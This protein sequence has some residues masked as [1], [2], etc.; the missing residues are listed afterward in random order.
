MDFICIDNKVYCILK[1]TR[2]Y[3]RNLLLM[4]CVPFITWQPV[5]N[6]NMLYRLSCN[7][8]TFYSFSYYCIYYCIPVQILKCTFLYIMIIDCLSLN[9]FFYMC[10]FMVSLKFQKSLGFIVFVVYAPWYFKRVKT[11]LYYSNSHWWWQTT[12]SAQ[13]W[14]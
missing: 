13:I 2:M 7:G 8:L 12:L 10:I 1:I 5:C 11:N 14:W 3:A 4:L 9:Q 6:W